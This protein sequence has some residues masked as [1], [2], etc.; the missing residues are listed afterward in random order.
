MSE[1]I[2][3]KSFA[4]HMEA[5]IAK[6]LLESCGIHTRIFPDDFSGPYRPLQII[7]GIKLQVIHQQT[8]EAIQLLATDTLFSDTIFFSQ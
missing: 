6:S 1:W 4:N 5:E 2:T 8:D 3:I 7:K